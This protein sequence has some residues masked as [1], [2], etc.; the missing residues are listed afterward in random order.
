MMEVQPQHLSLYGLLNN[1][2]FRIPQYQ[3]A[4]SWVSKQRKDL[5]EDIETGYRKENTEHFMA[6][7]VGLRRETRNV[8]AI[9]FQ[10]ID[11]VDGQ[12]RITTLILILKAIAKAIDSNNP[13]AASIKNQI[14]NLLIK[15]DEAS[16]LL[17]QTNHDTSQYFANYIRNSECP[18]P[19]K[20]KTLADRQLLVA[21]SECE[22]F[23]SKW[24]HSLVELYSYLMN[25]LTFIFHEISNEST[26]Y[27]VFEV[28]NSRGLPVSWFDR[29]KSMLMGVVFDSETENRQEIIDEV[30]TLWADIYRTIG[31]RM[32]LST[33]ALRFAATLRS[34]NRPGRTLSEE[35]SVETLMSQSTTPSEVIET[36]RWILRVIEAV[37]ALRADTR[38][39]AV[40]EFA[41]ARLVA[42][43]VELRNDLT[44]DEKRRIFSLW[45][46][47][48][49]RIYGLCGRDARSG[50]NPYMNLAWNIHK[51]NL[52]VQEIVSG[53]GVIG[54]RYANNQSSIRFELATLYNYYYER[55]RRLNSVEL[56][57][58]FHR[59][60]EY[61]SKKA[62]Q[63]FN[64]EQWNRIWE[65]SASNSIEHILPQS[66][67]EEYIHSLG[68]LTMLQPNLNSRLKDNTPKDK[69]AEYIKTGLLDARDVAARIHA[70]GGKWREKEILSREREL[71]DWA[72]KEWA[73]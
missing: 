47:I 63:N 56:R 11:I 49:F 66:S 14:D 1:R 67:E 44:S 12:Q 24:K 31:L 7:I 21:M 15:Q 8:M 43:A 50:V 45:E 42:V 25:H 9:N 58:F 73:D 26:V 40:T 69:A 57:Y 20:A 53:L 10:I 51:N 39:S 30:H 59:Y 33:E 62:G 54:G 48:T 36:S 6:T 19:N 37:N 60:E 65:S 22:A 5:F 64:N 4:Y 13:S 3:R 17:L 41:H 34:K 71:I 35:V 2:L 70:A 72:A 27:S 23:V 38:R 52:S 28:L 55:A 29:L 61:L 16:Q 68:N 46:K 32:G 18:E